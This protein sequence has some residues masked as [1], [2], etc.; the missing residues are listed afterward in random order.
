MFGSTGVT[1]TRPPETTTLRVDG[2]RVIEGG[3]VVQPT[4]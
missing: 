2:G 3:R 4:G 1:L